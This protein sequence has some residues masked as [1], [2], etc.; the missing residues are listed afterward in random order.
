MTPPSMARSA[1][2]LVS[3]A[4]A[5]VR[6]P[7]RG[8]YTRCC[9]AVPRAGS[10]GHP[11]RWIP[12]REH[13]RRLGARRGM[14]GATGA[15][16][17]GCVRRGGLRQDGRRRARSHFRFVPP[18][19]HFIPDSRKDSVPLFLKQ[20]CDRT[21]GRHLLQPASE[22]RVLRGQ[23]R[24]GPIRPRG[25]VQLPARSGLRFGLVHSV[26]LYAG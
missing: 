15:K 24:R 4:G 11:R 19:I 6:S 10:D 12:S 23:P 8:P 1:A 26:C 5:Q 22:D 18:L 2:S 9:P 16:D 17:S 13:G 20:Q 7:A 3:A 25:S 21:L 14:P